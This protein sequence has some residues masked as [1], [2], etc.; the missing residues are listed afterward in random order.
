[1]R[2]GCLEFKSYL[3]HQFKGFHCGL[4]L[5]R[6]IKTDSQHLEKV[7]R[8]PFSLYSLLCKPFLYMNKQL[9]N[10][11]KTNKKKTKETMLRKYVMKYLFYYSF[12]CFCSD[13]V[14]GGAAQWS[15]GQLGR[16]PGCYG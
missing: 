3:E 11:K 13:S 10:Y 16:G 12:V 1:M 4:G 7:A 2:G 9:C 14:L 6:S 5:T 8:M 15:P